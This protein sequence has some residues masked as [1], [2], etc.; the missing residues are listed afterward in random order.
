MSGGLSGLVAR[1]PT[2]FAGVWMLTAALFAVS[3]VAVP[4]SVTGAALQSMLPFAAILAVATI[5][6]TLVVQQGGIDL[7]PAGVVSLTC[8]LVVQVSG[9]SDAGLP[10]A[11]V[12]ALGCA[13]GTGAVTG[14]AITL[15]GVNPL[16]ATLAVN[17]LLTGVV[18][19]VT[20]G[21]M[22]ASTPAALTAFVGHRVLGVQVVVWVAVLVVGATAWAVSRTVAGRRFAVVGAGREA[23]HAMGLPVRRVEAGTYVCAALAYGAAGVLLAGFLGRPG[24]YQ[25]DDYLL[26]TIAA[27]AIGG[28]ALGGG[29]GSVVASAAGALFLT[30]LG[31]VVLGTGAPTAVQYLIQAGVIVLG[32]GLRGRV[33]LARVVGAR[34]RRPQL[35]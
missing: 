20:G 8:V 16:V 32:I 23:A 5:G 11:L 13:A 14:I 12:V 19:F 10:V 25:G 4:G 2:R 27:V 28:T 6:Q 3:A 34:L 30:Q 33:P 31:Q 18:L 35:Q 24:V 1:I 29:R 9:G 26:S 15:L 22:S 21:N 17:A 7:S